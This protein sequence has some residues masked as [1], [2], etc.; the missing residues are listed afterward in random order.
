[1][2][3]KIKQ[4]G[5]SEPTVAFI[6]SYLSD[7]QIKLKV[8][9]IKS[10]PVLLKAGTPQGAIISPTLFNIWVHDIPTPPE[11]VTMSQYADDIATWV[12][13][14]NY[15]TARDNL[16]KFNNDLLEWCKRWRI[17]LCADKTQ[18]IAF[19]RK[20]LSNPRAIYQVL[21]GTKIY[22][23]KTVEFLGIIIDNKMT[24]K[25]QHQKTM[26][27]LKRRR[28]MF[29][30]IT[31]STNKPRASSNICLKILKSMI[32]P[33]TAYAP[34]MTCL[35]TDKMFEEQDVQLRIAGR[36]AIHAPP[37]TRNE[38]ITKKTGIEATKLRTQSLGKRYLED[39]ARSQSM[40]E[41]II[42]QKARNKR[43]K[44]V[45]TPLEK[46]F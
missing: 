33:I 9:G 40:K 16:N 28:K 21:D 14:R 35:K 7:R 20:P 31:G 46:V 19:H 43:N 37:G 26:K 23:G 11:G 39:I 32:V 44:R 27:E 17:M 5:F 25:E 30:G 34:T 22:G 8:N 4:V 24:L 42:S 18:V 2:I 10:N 3:W 15:V 6:T 41:Y 45:E 36:L 1:M 38:Y 13:N 12:K 29:A